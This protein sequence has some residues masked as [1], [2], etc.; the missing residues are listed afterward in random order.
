MQIVSE[1]EK[2]VS[3]ISDIELKKIAFDRILEHL[4]QIGLPSP[5]GKPKK[6]KAATVKLEKKS[7]AKS[8][9]KNWIE[10]L[11][12]EGFFQTPKASND[13]REALDERGH[14][15]QSTDLTRPL[16]RLVKDKVLRRKK[17]PAE[18]GGKSQVHWYNW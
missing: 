9:P 10:E 5:E 6:V 11:V 7:S 13:I 8:G 1:A 16:D 14:I 17:M 15:L 2:A 12:D 18:E 3:N 4:L